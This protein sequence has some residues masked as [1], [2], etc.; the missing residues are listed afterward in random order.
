M[1]PYP[2]LTVTLTGGEVLNIQSRF[3]DMVAV[4]RAMHA[5]GLPGAQEAP[6][7]WSARVAWYAAR[8]ENLIDK[9]MP[10]EAFEEQI[11][12][13]EVAEA[14]EGASPAAPFPEG[15]V[16]APDLLDS[17]SDGRSPIVAVG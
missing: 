1:S 17:G 9:T 4:E 16:G 15:L 12:G 2:A 14:V 13:I 11:E 8:R 3:K 10:Y 5:E 6:M 7:G